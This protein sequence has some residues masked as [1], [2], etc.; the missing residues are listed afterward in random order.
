MRNLTVGSLAAVF[1]AITAVLPV[2][3]QVRLINMVPNS[4]S[5]ETNQ[6]S[7][8]TISVDPLNRNRMAGSAFTWDNLTGTSMT[9]A[10]API[11]F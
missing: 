1:L 5:G 11:Y 3:A 6:D 10:T 8:P 2:A 7:E 4:R 9:T